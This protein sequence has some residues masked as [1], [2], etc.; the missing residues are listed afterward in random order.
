MYRLKSKPS[1]GVVGYNDSLMMEDRQ[2]SETLNI[3]CTTGS[4][5]AESPSPAKRSECGPPLAQP[6]VLQD[7]KKARYGPSRRR[8]ARV[9]ADEVTE[10]LRLRR[11]YCQP[12]QRSE[13]RSPQGTATAHTPPPCCLCMLTSFNCLCGLVVR[14]P[15][16]RYRGPGSIPRAT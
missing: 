12:L 13:I 3:C 5:P 4:H 9:S 7:V 16:Y 2:F 11:S 10:R 15:G 1:S 6:S 8:E 14:L